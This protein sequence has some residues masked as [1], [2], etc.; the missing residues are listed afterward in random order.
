MLYGVGAWQKY[1]MVKDCRSSIY[2]IHIARAER[3][4]LSRRLQA[5]ED[6]GRPDVGLGVGSGRLDIPGACTVPGGPPG[7]PGTGMGIAAGGPV[8]RDRA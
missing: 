1:T 6:A 5:N 8:D 7:A 3:R 4:S 2:C